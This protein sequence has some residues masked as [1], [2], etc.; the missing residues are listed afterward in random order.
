[1]V[2]IF[3]Q[4]KSVFHS[5]YELK[6]EQDLFQ[7]FRKFLVGMGFGEESSNIEIYGFGRPDDGHH[8]PDT[9]KEEDIKD[10]VDEHY[11]FQNDEFM[12]DLIFGK[13]KIFLMVASKKDKQQE[14]NEKVRKFCSF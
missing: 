10:Y 9:S 3:G 8:D 14:I 12:I 6:K 2:K 5:F 13:E 11:F 1:M 4:S 7:G